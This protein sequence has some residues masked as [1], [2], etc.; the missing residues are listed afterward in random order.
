MLISVIIT[1]YNSPD[2]LEKCLKSFLEQDDKNFEI[3]VA[4]DGS[5]PST[6]DIIESFKDSSLKI[7][8]AWHEDEGFRAAKI[9]NEAVKLSS[10]E[11]LIFI[12]GDCIVFNDFI[13][14]HR[15][16]SEKG[17]FSRGNRAK[18]SQKFSKKIISEEDQ[19]KIGIFKL[20]WLRL[21]SDI[22]RLM[23]VL[24]FP[25]Y[26]FKKLQKKKWKGAKT[27]NLGVWKSDFEIVN[28]YDE[29]YIGWGREDSDFVVRLINN[30]I[31][32]KEAIFATGLL[33]LNH[34]II[35]R[36]NF[37]KNDKLLKDTIE[38]KKL[39]AKNG[40]KKQ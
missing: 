18:L 33:H 26:P 20:V 2:F 21:N 30:N 5:S 31:Y 36:E 8:H 19:N 6:K 25:N 11:F 9:R 24:R 37:S 27:C 34:K 28:G 38:N 12:D 10:G 35:S 40:Y 32:R 3:I 1:T 16:I 22:N 7:Y 23:P 4:D 15:N 39:C 17:F 14:N 13:K 29:S